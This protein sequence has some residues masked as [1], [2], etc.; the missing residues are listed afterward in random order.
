MKFIKLTEIDDKG[1]VIIASESILCA[2]PISIKFKNRD[3]GSVIL[4]KEMDTQPV[5]LDWFASGHKQTPIYL[6][7]KE[8]VDEIYNMLGGG[9]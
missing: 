1:A 9:K 8:S 5:Q 4:L 7:V 3:V 6:T 2:A